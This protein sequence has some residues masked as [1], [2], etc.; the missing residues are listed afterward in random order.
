MALPCS[1]LNLNLYRVFYTVAKTK[2]FSESSRTLHIAQPAIS[3]QIQNL[4]YELNTLLFYRTNRGIELTP[5]A[6][7]LLVYVEKAWNFLMLGE[8]QLQES[9]DLLKGKISIGV[10]TFISNYYLNDY[11]KKFMKEH[12]SIIIKMANQ[13]KEKL[14]ELL[15]QHTLDMLIITDN[16]ETP[17]DLKI[18]PLEKEHYCFAYNKEKMNLDN[19]NTLEELSKKQ[20]IVPVKNLIRKKLEELFNNKG[21]NLEPIMELENNEMIL[22]YVKEGVGIGFLLTKTVEKNPELEII[23]LE[24]ELPSSIV[25]LIYNENTLTSSSKEF[26]NLLTNIDIQKL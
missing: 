5:E 12:P 22:N 6:K 17:K 14:F 8:K 20:L 23:E 9:K 3:K 7:A 13:D 11:V 25:S 26:I 24:E 2:S 16:I 19:V 21:V 18:I 15:Q 1:N 4:E 10:Q